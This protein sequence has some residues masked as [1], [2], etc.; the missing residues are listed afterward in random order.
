MSMLDIVDI[1]VDVNAHLWTKG[2]SEKIKRKYVNNNFN[3][4]DK[5]LPIEILCYSFHVKKWLN[6]DWDCLCSFFLHL[7]QKY[8]LSYSSIVVT[9]IC[10]LTM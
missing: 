6:H 4:E 5:T 3:I 2:T 9:E 8:F 7:I 10:F 1:E